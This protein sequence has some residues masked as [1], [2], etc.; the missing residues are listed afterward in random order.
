MLLP[1]LSMLGLAFLSGQAY[2]SAFCTVLPSRDGYA[3]LRDKPSI[4]GKLIWRMKP[5]EMVQIDRTRPSGKGWSAVIY[6]NA[7]RRIVRFGWV[8]GR[9]IEK[10][11]G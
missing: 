2:A 8:A 9:L 10:E 7:E 6:R 3:A 11:C 4:S 1:I 5:D